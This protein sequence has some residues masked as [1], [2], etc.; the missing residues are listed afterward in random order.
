MITRTPKQTLHGWWRLHP[1]LCLRKTS[2]I[3][4]KKSTLSGTCLQDLCHI[5]DTILCFECQLQNLAANECLCGENDFNIKRAVLFNESPE[6]KNISPNSEVEC[7][8]SNQSRMQTRRKISKAFCCFFVFFC[9]QPIINLRLSSAFQRVLDCGIEFHVRL[10]GVDGFAG[11]D[12]VVLVIVRFEV[13][14]VNQ[15]GPVTHEEP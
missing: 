3:C 2:T 12:Q 1:R 5:E 8:C 10:L 7:L 14:E 13:Q 6:G 9:E 11:Q 15:S 4:R